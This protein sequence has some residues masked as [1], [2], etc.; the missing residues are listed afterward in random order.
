MLFEAA[1][2]M[3]TMTRQCNFCSGMCVFHLHIGSIAQLCVP[4]SLITQQPFQNNPSPCD[5]SIV[6][7]VKSKSENM[8]KAAPATSDSTSGD[9]GCSKKKR[10]LPFGSKTKTN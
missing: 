6:V 7:E 10:I 3:K 2:E 5:A 9:S 8:S 1:L 4:S